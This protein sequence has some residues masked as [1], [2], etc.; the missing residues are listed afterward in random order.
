MNAFKQL[1]LDPG[2]G[3]CYSGFR[4]GQQPG[5]AYPSYDEVYTDLLL[6]L[7][8][9]TYL[10]LYDVDKHGK[11]VCEVIQNEGLPFKVMLGA[12]IEAEANN[13]ACPWGGGVHSNAQLEANI[14]SN[15]AKI[16]KLIELANR[17]A[18]IVFSVSIGNEACV[19]WTDHLVPVERVIA[20]AKKTKQHIS[21]PVTFCENYVPWL[22][23]L[24]PLAEV[25][26]FISI[27]TYPV[28]EYKHIGEALA[29]TKSNYQ[30][31]ANRHPDKPIVIT[32]AGWTTATNGRGITPENVGEDFQA[33]Y[34]HEL[35]AW[36]DEEGIP[37]FFFEAFDES[38][39]GSND[40][41]EPEKHWGVYR[42]D[43]SPKKIIQSLFIHTI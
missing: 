26:D 4:R 6:L 11:L 30:D 22:D 42:E 14:V 38:W 37:T 2:R 9:W 34:Y 31:V 36:A 17:Y 20:M 7:D 43:R 13:H 41:L 39:K 21:Q 23:E 3:I 35:M 33:T 28:W 27:H 10:R 15:D 19:S 16:D 8:E 25:L 40:P 32:E 1:E 12:Y 24:A 18:E 29:Y 5:E